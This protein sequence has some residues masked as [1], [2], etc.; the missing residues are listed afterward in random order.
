M[1]SPIYKIKFSKFL[2][3]KILRWKLFTKFSSCTYSLVDWEEKLLEWM[4]SQKKCLKFL[5]SSYKNFILFYY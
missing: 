3:S 5:I 1:N 4:F 2:E